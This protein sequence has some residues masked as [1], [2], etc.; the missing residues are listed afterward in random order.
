MPDPRPESEPEIADASLL[1]GGA[2]APKGQGAPS[3]PVGRHSP[4]CAVEEPLEPEV[5]AATP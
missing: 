2:E 5:E 4:G 1:F 3:S